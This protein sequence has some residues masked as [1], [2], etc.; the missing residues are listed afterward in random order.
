MSL[1]IIFLIENMNGAKGKLGE[2]GFKVQGTLKQY[3]GSFNTN[4]SMICRHIEIFTKYPFSKE[5]N[6]NKEFFRI[7]GKKDVWSNTCFNYWNFISYSLF[8]FFYMKALKLIN[9]S[10]N[11]LKPPLVLHT[12]KVWKQFETFVVFFL[13]I[14]YIAV[15]IWCL[16]CQVNPECTFILR[17]S[18]IVKMLKISNIAFQRKK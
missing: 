14:Q 6:E 13:T 12:Y 15:L 9:C 10:K 5:M 17:A 3:L 4:N 1:G 2:V 7:L 18:K 8:Q 16:P 11:D